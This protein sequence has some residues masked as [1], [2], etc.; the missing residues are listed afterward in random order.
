MTQSPDLNPILERLEAESSK[1][2]SNISEIEKLKPLTDEIELVREC[3]NHLKGNL[4]FVKSA[5]DE[6]LLALKESVGHWESIRE[7]LKAHVRIENSELFKKS[8]ETLESAHRDMLE[9]LR[10]QSDERASRLESVVQNSQNTM[11]Q[12]ISSA[13]EQL[14]AELP[15]AKSVKVLTILM[16]LV[17]GI[18]ILMATGWN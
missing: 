15:S 14:R 18:L 1:L 17:L 9:K 6:T 12:E 10:E 2:A 7:E 11:S 8:T 4:T 3:V 13:E 16:V 5:H